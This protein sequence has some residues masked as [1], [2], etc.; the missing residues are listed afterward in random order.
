MLKLLLQP[1]RTRS[2]YLLL[3]V[4]LISIATMAISFAI[5]YLKR[6]LSYDKSWSNSENI[7]RVLVEQSRLLD[8]PD[9]VSDELNPLVFDELV[10]VIGPGLSA[11]TREYEAF[12]AIKDQA[13]SNFFVLNVVEPEFFQIFDYP[14]TH[15][16]LDDIF[17]DPYSIAL[18]RN[19]AEQVVGN[20]PIGKTIALEGSDGGAQV[21][22]IV[23]VFEQPELTA[24]Y[25]NMIA[26]KS[27][28]TLRLF[29]D[30]NEGAWNMP[31]KIWVGVKEQSIVRDFGRTQEDLIRRLVTGFDELLPPD[32]NIANHIKLHL[33]EIS[34][35][36]FNRSDLL[37]SN[38]RNGDLREAISISTVCIVI[39]LVCFSNSVLL[40]AAQHVENQKEILIRSAFGATKRD[41]LLSNLSLVLLYA[42]TCH[43]L[44]LFTIRLAQ[45]PSAAQYFGEVGSL[46]LVGS[47]LV[48]FAIQMAYI[49]GTISLPFFLLRIS[50]I[51]GSLASERRSQP[52]FRGAVLRW[53]VPLQFI[54]ASVMIYCSIMFSL[55][56]LYAE[57][58]DLGF[59]YENL[60]VIQNNPSRNVNLQQLRKELSD[61]DGVEA[62]TWALNPPN[63]GLGPSTNG[64]RLRRQS[65]ALGTL[66]TV[67]EFIPIGADFFTT[68]GMTL[69]AG[70]TP[71]IE[72]F[73]S[74]ASL[75]SDEGETKIFLNET[76]ARDL[77]FQQLDEVLGSRVQQI[78]QT[79]DGETVRNLR[80]LGVVKD[81]YYSSIASDIPPAYFYFSE[82]G[83]L[84][85]RLEEGY[86]S[87]I[88]TG[89][90]DVIREWFG[91]QPT[92]TY[93][94]PEITAGINP[95]RRTVQL[96]SILSVLIFLI[97]SAGLYGS[98][99]LQ[100]RKQ[101]KDIGIR[102]CMGA[103]LK[104]LVTYY[105]KKHIR[106]V[107]LAALLGMPLGVKLS[108]N[109]VQT[110][111]MQVGYSLFLVTYILLIAALLLLSVGTIVGAIA[112]CCAQRPVTLL[113]EL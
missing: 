22:N 4:V 87:R 75:A 77:G 32:D 10:N 85:A 12:V 97:A 48:L 37:G 31:H 94:D 65:D 67:A 53:A 61:I 15:G 58:Y 52:V 6:E 17:E 23:A 102:K 70:G 100:I 71:E 108:L 26:A 51:G 42:L 44:S 33:Q 1:I 105:C 55:Q 14:V 76:A 21:F 29:N 35:I 99:S 38:F 16:D 90:D 7:Y 5:L 28:H 112:K 81:S 88:V 27:E 56:Q 101:S 89:F 19:V 49:A 82:T 74:L 36:Y 95:Q 47:Y 24:T 91:E 72:S 45:S 80:V 60:V 59:D 64:T 69:I 2:R 104:D 66:A 39:A 9:S 111:P 73:Q 84:I 34:D 20:D 106:L 103:S 113:R 96:L 79:E 13:L 98:S 40:S 8:F 3:N 18:A 107:G 83:R 109:W 43:F 110:Y 93:L 25:R 46:D 30:D 68:M 57:N 63:A 41:L 78:I 11:S 92:L 50:R 62:V 86:A 54:L